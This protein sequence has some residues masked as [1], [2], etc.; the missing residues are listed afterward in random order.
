M[1]AML[2]TVLVLAGCLALAPA[3]DPALAPAF[4]Q[5]A[6]PPSKGPGVADTIMRLEKD[7][8]DAMIAGDLDRLTQIVADDWFDG[9]PGKGDT[10][11][12]FLA[13]VRSSKH[14]LVAFDFGPSDVKVFG[15]VA[16][17]QGSVTETSAGDGQRSTIQVAYMDVWVKRG[18]KWVV[19][20]SFSKKL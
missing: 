14:K 4:A 2:K 16:V 8:L 10:K 15:D 3:L 7:W 5:P 11:A 19:F 1:K 13:G 17:A 9:Y 18:D 20:R 12:N 6:G